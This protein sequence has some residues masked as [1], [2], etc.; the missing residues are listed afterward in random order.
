MRDKNDQKQNLLVFSHLRWNFVFQRPQHLLTR[1]A[2]QYRVLFIEEPVPGEQDGYK[3]YDNSGIRVVTPEL[4]G[5]WAGKRE[6]MMRIIDSIIADHAIEKHLSWYYTPMF[7]EETRHL[8]PD[9]VI[10]DCMDELS[11]F[12]FAPPELIALEAELFKRA[13]VVF[14]GGQSPF[15]A[16][17]DKHPNVHCFP[18][19]IDYKH[20]AKARAPLADPEAQRD[21]GSPRVGFFGVVDERFDCGL[22]GETAAMI[23]AVHFMVVGP[24]VKIDPAILPQ[25]PNIHYLGKREYAELPEFIANW[26]VAMMPF[27]LNESTKYISPTKTPEYLAAGKPVISTPI[28]DVVHPYGRFDNVAIIHNAQEF[29]Q[30]IESFLATEQTGERE[31]DWNR[32]DDYLAGMSWQKTSMAMCSIIEEALERKDLKI[33]IQ[34]RPLATPIRKPVGQILEPIGQSIRTAST[35]LEPNKQSLAA[36]VQSQDAKSKA[37]LG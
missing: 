18:S 31:E 26:N 21:A 3:A 15:N 24:V 11:A 19:S 6:R 17:K 12:K 34:N 30:A 29:R 9:L 5:E 4:A 2:Q 16:K 23:P 25:G 10:Y 1:I 33:V 28:T 35:A 20:F 14:T 37:V 36:N 13:D 32:V 27:A 8:K 22:L 7:L